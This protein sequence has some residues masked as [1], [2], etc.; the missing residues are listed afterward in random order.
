[1]PCTN[2]D[3]WILA[4]RLRWQRIPAHLLDQIS[5]RKG[6]GAVR[7]A[8]VA[9]AAD[10]TPQHSTDKHLEKLRLQKG[11]DAQFILMGMMT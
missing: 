10:V 7:R 4:E 1:M 6:I 9:L 2:T 8:N 11:R 3:R 5:E